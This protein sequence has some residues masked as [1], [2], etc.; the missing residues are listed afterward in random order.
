MAESLAFDGWQDWELSWAPRLAAKFSGA[1]GAPPSSS[2]RQDL[3]GAALP[4]QR[5]LGPS[6]EVVDLED[7]RGARNVVLVLHRGF[8]GNVCITCS[9]YTRALAAGVGDFAARDAQVFLVYP[10]PAGAVPAFLEAVKNLGTEAPPPFP[11]LLDIDLRT[12]RALRAE[13]DLAMP[14][15]IIVD[16]QGLVRFAYTGADKDDRPSIPALLAELDA[17]AG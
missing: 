1:D 7:L 15:A 10:G 16:K 11:V 4:Q 2:N 9:T 8:S 3:L 12:V 6:G 13:G 17:L 14:T 5:F